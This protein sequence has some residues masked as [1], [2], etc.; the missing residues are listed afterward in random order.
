MSQTITTKGII[1]KLSALMFMEWGVKA[2]WMP[3]AGIFLVTDTSLGGLGFTETQKGMI[4]GIPMATACFLAPFIAGQLTD[5]LFPTQRVIAVMLILAGIIKFS[6]AYQTGFAV[7]MTLSIS[8]AP[9]RDGMRTPSKKRGLTEVRRVP[10]L[11]ARL[12]R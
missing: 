9:R 7:W 8:F 3:L 2:F 10:R 6:N 1:P 4:I 5:R 12:R 11:S